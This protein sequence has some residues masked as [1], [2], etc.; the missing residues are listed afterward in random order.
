MTNEK[1]IEERAKLEAELAKGQQALAALQ[2]QQGATIATMQRIQGAMQF[3]DGLTAEVLAER[4][5][6]P[7]K[8]V[9]DPEPKAVAEPTLA[10]EIVEDEPE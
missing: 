10:P 8:T 9:G 4:Q 6:V 7:C 2:K 3:I 1:M 5:E